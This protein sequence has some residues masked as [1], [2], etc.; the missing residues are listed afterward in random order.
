MTDAVVLA[1][2]VVVVMLVMGSMVTMVALAYTA[3]L[4]VL[5]AM[6]ADTATRSR[7]LML[8]I[9]SMMLAFQK[10]HR[11]CSVIVARV[12]REMVVARRIGG[13]ILVGIEEAGIMICRG[14]VVVAMVGKMSI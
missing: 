8:R 11:P 2:A 4:I 5:A 9:I 1:V 14:I 13:V 3:L 10:G 12:T 6:V 7:S